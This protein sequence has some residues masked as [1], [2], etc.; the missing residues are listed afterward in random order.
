MRTL[1][2]VSVEEKPRPS[3]VYQI[4]QHRCHPQ[5]CGG[6]IKDLTPGEKNVRSDVCLDGETL[7]SWASHRWVAFRLREAVFGG[8]LWL[9]FASPSRL[10]A[11]YI[12]RFLS[13]VKRVEIPQGGCDTVYIIFFSSVLSF[14]LHASQTELWRIITYVIGYV[15]MYKHKVTYS[16]SFVYMYT[17]KEVLLDIYLCWFNSMH[18]K[19]KKILLHRHLN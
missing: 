18:E 10:T 4:F 19:K 16:L 9:P 13:V 15:S 7:A 17:K 1:G 11:N 12:I 5:S 14:L 3:T 2:A 6:Q 8:L